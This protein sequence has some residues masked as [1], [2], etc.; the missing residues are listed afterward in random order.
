MGGSRGR[1]AKD[2]GVLI[3]FFFPSLFPSPSISFLLPFSEVW[4]I[5]WDQGVANV[6][7]EPRMGGV[8]PKAENKKVTFAKLDDKV[9][10]SCCLL[11][12]RMQ[13]N[14]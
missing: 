13:N 3:S 9:V 8:W 4:K 12:L 6:D 1:V 11:L 7:P 14:N 2:L 5:A 10:S